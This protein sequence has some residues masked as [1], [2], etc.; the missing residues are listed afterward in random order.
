MRLFN[1]EIKVQRLYKIHRNVTIK[2]VLNGYLLNDIFFATKPEMF[3]FLKVY[4]LDDG[5]GVAPAVP[6]YIQC[7]L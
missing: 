4:L 6:K 1:L 3:E 7:Q 2:E 5:E